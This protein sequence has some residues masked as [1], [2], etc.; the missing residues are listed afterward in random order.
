MKTLTNSLLIVACILCT[1]V[2]A[3]DN[4]IIDETHASMGF[5]VSHLVISNVK[6]HFNSFTGSVTLNEKNEVVA[7][8]STIQASSID[9]GNEKRDEHLRSADFFEVEKFPEIS[10]KSE[11]T[12]KRDGKNFLIGKFTIHG[13]TKNLQLQYSIKGPIKDPWGNKKIGFQAN[14]EINRTDFG[15]NWNKA[16]ETGGVVVGEKVQLS[17]DFEA[18]KK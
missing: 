14:G 5:S 4:Y 10:F 12:I 7:A 9:T 8:E 6:G 17:I 2:Q 11:K 3:E 15:L 1:N 13:I 18:A 16:L